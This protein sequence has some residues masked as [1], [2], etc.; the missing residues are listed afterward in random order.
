MK[1]LIACEFSG[2]VRD[3]FSKRGHDAWSCDLLPTE[4]LGQHLVGDVLCL[5]STCKWDLM[6]AHPPCTYLSN[7]G[8]HH[9]HKRKGRF[10][11]MRKAADFFNTLKSA[12]IPRIAIENPTPHHYARNLIGDYQQAIQP[13]EF[14]VPETKRTCLWLKNL[15]PLMATIIET[16]RHPRVHLTP[17]GPNRWKERS[18]TPQG[19]ADAMAKQWG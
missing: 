10:E 1:V 3:A 19:I 12:P 15:P 7:S 6:I 18:R 16:K 5:L 9:L 14:G 17:P 2:V 4:S 13:Y 11:E 8:V